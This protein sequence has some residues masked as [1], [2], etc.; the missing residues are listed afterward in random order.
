MFF[1]K[2]PSL[3]VL[4]PHKWRDEHADILSSVAFPQPPLLVR[5]HLQNPIAHCCCRYDSSLSFRTLL[6]SAAGLSFAA[7]SGIEATILDMRLQS[8]DLL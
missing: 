7:H 2:A 8:Y 1:W 5:V 3:S 6:S 4:H